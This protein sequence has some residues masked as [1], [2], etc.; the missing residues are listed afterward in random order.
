MKRI[1][2]SKNLAGVV[3]LVFFHTTLLSST[4]LADN[5]RT[6]ACFVLAK[7]ADQEQAAA[8]M[9]SILRDNMGKLVG[10]SV[11]TGAPAGNEQAA[12]EVE[13][14][15]GEGFRSL[16]TG[17]KVGALAKFQ[18]A[19]DVLAQNPGVGTARL[20]AR[21]AKGLG[22][23]LFMNGQTTRGKDLIKR[24][25]LLHSKQTPNE[26]AYSVEVRNL[27]DHAKRE[28][29]DMAQGTIQV[30]STPDGAETYLDGVFKG[31]APMSLAN[32]PPGSHL[33]E[34]VKDGYLRWSTDALVKEGAPTQAE[35]ILTPSPTRREM[36]RALATVKKSM[37]RSRFGSAAA[38]L[39]QA[40]DA[41]EAFVVHAAVGGNGFR[42]EGFYRDLAG[43]VQP[44]KETIAQDASFF[45][46]VRQM[47]SQ[48]LAAAFQPEG[49]GEGLDAPPKAVVDSVMKQVGSLGGDIAIDP[50]SPLFRIDEKGGDDPIT[51]K[52]WFWTIIGVGAAAVAGTVTA[53]VLATG[54]EEED[55][56]AVG[57]LTITFETFGN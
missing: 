6:I 16:N 17:D 50:D 56:G 10:I 20:H 32:V 51:S 27:Y 3:A 31:Y 11:R 42:L 12:V 54:D 57:N 39:M 36:E 1:A 22:V 8:V 38:E 4:A 13:R 47:L 55:K 37:T 33:L 29:T 15:S 40:V 41:K 25:L 45:A 19:W 43:N 23:C 18:K 24:S 30:R 5:G 52:W 44:I 28:I 14:L 21:V 7:K 34:M 26:Y 46:T 9:S 35:A 48:N 2:R 49:A 53:I